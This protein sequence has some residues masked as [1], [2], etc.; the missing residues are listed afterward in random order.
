[1]SAGRR[2]TFE[3]RVL[4]L[5]LLTGLPGSGI[6]LLL[7]WSGDFA[8][9][10]QWTLTAFVVILWWGFAFSLRGRVVFPLWTASNLLAALREGD[11]SI[12]ARGARRED[13]LGELML[14][15][16]S[17]AQ[18]LHDERLDALEATALL[19]KIMTEIDVAIFAFDGD[20]RLRLVNRAGGRLL[21]GPLERLLGR[22]A[23]ELGLDDCLAGESPRVVEKS[24]PGGAGRWEV[25]RGEFRQ[26]GMPLQMLVIADLSRA[27]RQEERQAWQRLIRVL[28]HELRNSLTPIR[29]IAGSLATLLRR[30]PRPEDWEEDLRRGL[31]VIAERS[32][33]LKRFMDAY[34]RLARLPEPRRA[35]VELGALVRRAAGL[36]TRMR[37]ALEPGPEV[38]VSAD[39]DQ[40]EQALINL[41]R[42]AVDAARETGGGV[43][44]G[45]SRNGAHCEIWVRDEGPGLPDTSNLFVP[46]FTT[47]PDGSGIGIVLCRQ[48]AEAHGGSLVLRNRD[49]GPGCEARLRLPAGP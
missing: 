43:R 20:R 49:P 35:P 37:V 26:G 19:R 38:V 31:A 22:R 24:F 45:W 17:L 30:D 14:E 41:I 6:A 3:R 39:G 36:E 42:N 27:L 40:I 29:S 11:F 13:A 47:K 9:R 16:N 12:R 4:M 46:F 1:M 48:I 23:A 7:L 5:A 10:T 15:V 28:G 2:L 25:R 44:V 32:G 34:S 18:T 21:G 8:P 33:S